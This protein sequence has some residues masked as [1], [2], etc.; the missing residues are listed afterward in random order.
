MGN[1]VKL[2]DVDG[3]DAE[4]TIN[5]EK[6]TISVNANIYLYGDGAT[7]QVAQAYKD[8]IMNSWGA[9]NEYEYKDKTFTVTWNINVELAKNGEPM[10]FDGVNNYIECKKD[11]DISTTEMNKGTWRSRSSSGG[12]LTSE[13]DNPAIHEFGHIVGLRD[14]YVTIKQAIKSGWAYG[15]ILEGWEGNVMAEP[16][17]KGVVEPV[18]LDI[19]FS[20]LVELHKWMMDQYE[21]N[22]PSSPRRFPYDN[23]SYKINENNREPNIYITPKNNSK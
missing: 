14:R 21:K 8:C 15:T 23:K 22:F 3:R 20:P 11:I 10:V 6:G 9:L 16:A 1:P 17:G 12:L 4:I 19:L 18:N 7:K 2:V 5:W 13:G